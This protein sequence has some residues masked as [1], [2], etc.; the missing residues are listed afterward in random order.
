MKIDL[1]NPNPG[2]WC[3]YPSGER[4]KLRLCVGEILRKLK[5]KYTEEKAEF[6]DGKR[7]T[8][9]KFPTDEVAYENEFW[10]HVIVDWEGFTDAEGNAIPCASESKKIMIQNV[11]GFMLATA[12]L[13]TQ[14]E[15]AFQIDQEEEGKNSLS[16]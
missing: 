13:V 9:E 3:T 15:L 10:D 5:T 1:K 7:I 12:K 8:W 16:S 4:I 11:P 14:I 2:T 6:V